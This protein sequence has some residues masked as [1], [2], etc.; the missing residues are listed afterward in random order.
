MPRSRDC[1]RWLRR[2]LCRAGLRRAPVRV[3]LVDRRN[4]HLFQPMLYQVATAALNPS[5]IAAPLRSVLRKQSNTEVLLAEVSSID[6]TD[7]RVAFTDGSRHDLR[8]PGRRHRRA[9][10]LLRP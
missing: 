7:R 8:L 6:T 5:D 10:L 1:W 4:H 2:A 3:T 9:T